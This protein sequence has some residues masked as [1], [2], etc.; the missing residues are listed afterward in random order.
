MSNLSNKSNQSAK[1]TK[2][3]KTRTQS[4]DGTKTSASKAHRSPA[5]SA[6]NIP[7]GVL[8]YPGAGT[9]AQHPALIALERALLAEFPGLTVSRVDFPY[10]REGRKMLDRAPKLVAAVHDEVLSFAQS[11]GVPTSALVIGGRSM[12]GRM[13]SM[14]IAEGLKVAGL[15]C[16]SYPLHPPKKPEKLRI[17]HLSHVT[18]P[19]LF[20]SGSRDEFGT[21]DEL[22]THISVVPGPTEL[23][24]VEG[25]GHDLAKGDGEIAAATIQWLRNLQ[26]VTGIDSA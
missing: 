15:L 1:S 14:A 23:R 11:L 20:I 25:K 19:S 26:P 12:G 3:T 8:L 13:C 24:I 6:S 9:D 18:T 16:M 17:E 4:T 2:S 5:H 22:R 7:A 21:P 10:R